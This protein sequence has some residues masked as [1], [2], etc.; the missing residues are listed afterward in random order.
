MT[1]KR[2][3]TVNILATIAF[4]FLFL[5]PLIAFMGKNTQAGATATEAS[6]SGDYVFFVVS[7]NDE[8]PLAAAPAENMSSYVVWISLASLTIVLIF[9]YS[10]WYMNI[11]KITNE[12]SYKLSPNERGSYMIHQGFLHPVRSYQL[13][14]EAENTVASMY[15][16]QM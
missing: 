1:F 5:L 15:I 14:K 16:G 7:D 9:S 8:V 2:K 12:L 4:V 10:A 3:I 13:A 11:R 6:S